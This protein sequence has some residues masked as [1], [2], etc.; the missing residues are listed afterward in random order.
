MGMNISLED[1]DI[2]SLRYIPR[3]RND[4]LYDYSILNFLS[5]VPT[6]FYSGCTI[7]LFYQHHTGAFIYPHALVIL[8]L[9][10][11]NHPSKTII[12]FDLHF[13]DD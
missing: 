4:W 9:V 5:K 10:D 13:T 3:N 11:N 7:F 12:C 8:C 2:N 6:N 1:P